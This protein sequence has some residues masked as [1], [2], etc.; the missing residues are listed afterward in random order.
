MTSKE[1]R[2]GF[3]NAFG[4]VQSELLQEI[5]YQLAL[6]NEREAARDA[7]QQKSY[8]EMCYDSK[9]YYEKYNAAIRELNKPVDPLNPEE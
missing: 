5:A 1:I 8:N 6:A 4:S 3:I 7:H 2:E 9:M